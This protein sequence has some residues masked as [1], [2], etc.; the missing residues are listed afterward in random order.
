MKIRIGNDIS[1]NVTLNYSSSSDEVNINSVRAFLINITKKEEIE[2]ELKN[3]TKFIK[4]FPIEPFDDAYSSN[5]HDIKSCGIPHWNHLPY[6]GFGVNPNWE[7]VY[8]HTPSIDITKYEAQVKYTDDK[9]VVKISFPAEDQ[10]YTGTYNLVIVAN[11]YEEGYS[12]DNLRT[13]TIDYTN[14]FILV[15]ST[16]VDV[17]GEITI[18][19]TYNK[20]GENL[21]DDS[22]PGLDKIS[23]DDQIFSND[24]EQQTNSLSKTVSVE[25]NG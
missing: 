8:G 4:R 15:D 5:A 17:D 1:L 6:V 19:V 7:Y 16:E 10:L 23:L 3:A 13:F 22:K 12:S 9:N 11:V 25:D 2:K 14:V 18:D 21:S 20:L 24:A